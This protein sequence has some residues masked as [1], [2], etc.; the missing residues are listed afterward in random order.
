MPVVVMPDGRKVR[1]PNNM[2]K[3]EIAS[4]IRKRYP[5]AG[6]NMAPDEVNTSEIQSDSQ[7]EQESAPVSKGRAVLEQGLQGAT[8]GFSDELVNR[9]G[10]LYASAVTGESYDDLYNEAKETTRNR[11]QAQKEQYPVTS[12]VSQLGGGVLTGLGTGAT[13][14][15]ANITKKIASRGMPTKLGAGATGGAVAAGLYGAGEAD[16]GQRIEEAKKAAIPG[17]VL[18]AAAPAVVQGIKST[19]LPNVEE[20]VKPLANRAKEFGIPLTMQQVSPTKARTTF[21]KVTSKLPF[22]GQE[23]FQERQIQS[24]NKAVAKTIGQDSKDL[25]PETIKKFKDTAQKK[26]GEVLHNKNVNIDSADILDIESLLDDIEL[27]TVEDSAKI[28]TKNVDRV[29]RDINAGLTDGV[30]KGSKLAQIRSDLLKRFIKTKNYE[31]ADKLGDIIDKVDNIVIKNIPKDKAAVLK[32]ARREWRNYKTIHPLLQKSERGL[33]N[34]TLLMN[35]VAQNPYIDASVKKVGEDDLVDLA[36]IGKE[37]L[38]KLGG[39]DT[40]EQ[41]ATVGGTGYLSHAAATND[42]LTPALYAG[43]ALGVGS[44]IQGLGRSQPLVSK[45]IQAGQSIP[46]PF[47]S[48]ILAGRVAEEY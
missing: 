10:A 48:S 17:A 19:I 44:A 45:A 34:P 33:I 30:M 36:R 11:M 25:G 18:G 22:S 43:G 5:D 29:V 26:F 39:S 2:P 35:R 20:V 47:L 24:F 3:Q 21:D 8:F 28:V 32:Q 31:V 38:P 37:F 41:L 40:Y 13:K 16:E 42:L 46:N 15:G 23:A 7:I 4:I 1:F 9:L 27:T 6:L 14:L 12:G